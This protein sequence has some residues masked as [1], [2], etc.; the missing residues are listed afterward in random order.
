LRLFKHSKP[1]R[2]QEDNKD[3]LAS[4]ISIERIVIGIINQARQVNREQPGNLATLRTLTRVIVLEQIHQAPLELPERVRQ[5]RQV[6]AERIHQ[7]QQGP[8][9]QADQEATEPLEQLIVHLRTRP[10]MIAQELLVTRAAVP[11]AHHQPVEELDLRM[12]MEVVAPAMLRVL[13]LQ[14]QQEHGKQKEKRIILLHRAHETRM[15]N[16]LSKLVR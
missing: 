11:L 15:T 6:L 12:E 3:S 1:I 13:P 14:V 8:L 9:E 7:E 2:R 4:L 5:E 16:K 10:H